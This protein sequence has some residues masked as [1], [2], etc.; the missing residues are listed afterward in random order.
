MLE[1]N[2][3]TPI[4]QQI[5]DYIKA[6]VVSG[7]FPPG[8][9]IPSI[10]EMSEAIKVNSNTVARAYQE[11]ER[12]GVIFTQRGIGAYISEKPDLINELRLEMSQAYLVEFTDSMRDLGYKPDEIIT[13]LRDFLSGR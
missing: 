11:L 5:S 7:N 1:F 10:R 2:D 9:K 3:K 13:A 8:Y 4:F 6:N 12:L